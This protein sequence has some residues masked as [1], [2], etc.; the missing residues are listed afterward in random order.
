VG[1]Y[2]G[3]I[4]SWLGRAMVGQGSFGVGSA[5]IIQ[6]NHESCINVVLVE[7]FVVAIVPREVNNFWG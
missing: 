1:D 5:Y 3:R 4:G 7:G 2:A 6:L